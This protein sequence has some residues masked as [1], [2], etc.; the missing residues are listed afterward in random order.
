MKLRPTIFAILLALGVLPLLTLVAVNLRGHIQKHDEIEEQRTRIWNESNG[1][2]LNAHTA[3]ISKTLFLAAATALTMDQDKA[4]DRAAIPSPDLKRLE[5]L[6]LSLLS[7]EKAIRDLS[8]LDHHGAT[9]LRLIRDNG[10][11]LH[12][13]PPRE[14]E[15]ST[16]L[17]YIQ[18]ALQLERFAMAA[19]FPAP[20]DNTP[21]EE[22]LLTLVTPV[23]NSEGMPLGMVLLKIE[24]HLFLSAH[25]NG[26]WI[27]NQGTLLH[28]PAKTAAGPDTDRD[29]ATTP[30]IGNNLFAALPNLQESMQGKRPF[31]WKGPEDRVIAWLPLIFNPHHAPLLW[32]G[33][34]V[35][36]SAAKEWKRS[37]IYNIIGIV[38]TITIVVSLIANAIAKKIDRIKNSILTGVDAILNNKQEDVRFVWTGP[39][40]V[41]NLAE[42][43][44]SLARHHTVTQKRQQEAEAALRQSEEEARLQQQQLIQADKMIS[45]GVLISGMAHEINNPNS[46]AMLNAAML[47]K[48][49]ESICP[50]L[51]E[52]YQENGDFLLAG[53]EY[54]EMRPQIPRLFSELE[55]SARRIRNIVQDLK[56]YARQD[57]TRCMERLDLNEV[58][59]AAIRLNDNKIRNAT[60]HFSTGLAPD[61]PLIQ[62]NRQRLEQVLI[63]LIQNS[64]EAL[65]SP[66]GAISVVS[67]HEAATNE[68]LL[69]VQDTGAGICPGHMNQITDPFF[70]T[71]RSS[72]GIGLG[73][74]VS[75]G[76]VKEHGGRLIFSSVPGKSTVATVALPGIPPS[77][78]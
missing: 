71:K 66:E 6:F 76:I 29:P 7:E 45:L 46:I 16:N 37:L 35:D 49:W 19:F 24:P 20:R 60:R 42:E 55:D 15:N 30:A 26:Y 38:V 8:L 52:Y 59:L 47:R 13:P 53:L 50:I 41:V 56:E 58:A 2:T 21:P 73:L 63:N 31:V 18:A 57:T 72:G 67:R 5:Q 3:S 61:L 68:V 34:P 65:C 1:L 39:R 70:T 36:R 78:Q 22:N 23:V 11:E 62:G 10:D 27:D 74:S 77:P 14:R 32:I 4:P 51:E 33:T 69:S 44:T 28:L 64:C 40:E 25:Q 9:M 54:S 17:Q 12:A 43:L 75:A 48:A